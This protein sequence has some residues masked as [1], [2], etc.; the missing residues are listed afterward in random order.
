[1]NSIPQ[2]MKSSGEVET[3]RAVEVILQ[4]ALLRTINISLS[5]GTTAKREQKYE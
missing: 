1:M 3:K 4:L 5:D 2:G